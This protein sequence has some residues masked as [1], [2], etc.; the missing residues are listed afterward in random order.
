MDRMIDLKMS[1][2][3]LG[4][5]LYRKVAICLYFVIFTINLKYY[6]TRCI[7]LLFSEYFGYN[8]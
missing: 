6:V 4:I 5:I 3:Y 8:N 2:G 7:G 1:I